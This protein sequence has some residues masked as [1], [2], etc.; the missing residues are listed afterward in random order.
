MDIGQIFAAIGSDVVKNTTLQAI[1]F[2][3]VLDFVLGTLKALAPPSTFNIKWVDAWVGDHLVKAVAI[4][5]AVVFGIVA[6]DIKLGDFSF[7]LVAVAAEAAAVTYV[8]KTASSALG[9]LNF[10][11]SDP[12]PASVV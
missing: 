9:N 5:F 10:G 11:S 2:I 4:S 7:N 1:F 6:P 8:A 3:S 12:P